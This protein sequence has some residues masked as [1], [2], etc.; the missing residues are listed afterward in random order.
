M[1]NRYLPTALR[2]A[3]DKAA[4]DARIVAEEG[5]RDAIRRLGVADS[6]APAYLKDEKKELRRRLRAHA[7]ALG[8]AFDKTEDTQGTKRLVEAAAY[9]HW[10]RMLFARFLAERGLLRNPEHDVPVTLEDCR[11]L[12]EAEG[13]TDAWAIAERYA[14][15]MLPAVFRIDDPVLALDLDPV[16]TQKLHRLVTDLDAE[17]FQ[18]EDS[19]GWTYQFWRAAEKKAVNKSGVKIGA[20]ELPAVTQLF[21]EPYMVRFL[22]HNTLGAW[23]AGKKLAADP[24]LAQT[25]ADEDA[26]RAAC[27]PADY[28]FDML[29]FVREG[30][31]DPWR[32]AAGTFPGWPK[33]AKAITVLDPCCGSGHFLTEALA[34]LAALRQA[35]EHLSS[36]DSV[37]A[38]LRDNL[39]GL[40]I[41]GRCVQIAAFAVALTAW[42]IGGWQTLPLPQI[43]WVGA[44][45]PLP[46]REFIALADGK[47]ELEY[48]LAALHDLFAQAPVLGS[49]LEPSGGDLFESEKLKE[50]ERLLEPLL[51]KARKAEPEHSEGVIAARGMA[52][53]AEM[54]SKNFIL[55]ATN[56][57]FLHRRRQNSHLQDYLSKH[58]PASKE[59]LSS[60]MC[61][62]MLRSSKD[63]GTTALVLPQNCYFLKTYSEFRR[64]LVERSTFS[65]IARL[66][67]KAFSTPM[68]DYNMSLSIFSN[69]PPDKNYS[70]PTIDAAEHTEISEKIDDLLRAKAYGFRPQNALSTPNFMIEFEES[71]QKKRLSDYASSYQGSGLGDIRR[72]RQMFWEVKDFREK[73]VLHA[74]S[75]SAGKSYSGCSFATLWESGRGDLASHP[76]V[77]LRGRSAWNKS[78]VAVAWLGTLPAS[79]YHGWLYD[80]SASVIIPHKAS[81]LT[82]LWAYISSEEYN[83]DVRKINQKPQVANATLVEVPFD[84][85][86]WRKIAGERCL[87]GIPEPLSNDA[88]QWLFHGHPKAADLGTGLQVALARLCGYRWPAEVD[89]DMRLSDEAREWIAKAAKLP[90]GDN[91]GL[92]GVPPVAGEKS[93]ADRLRGYLAAAFGTDWSDALERRLIAEADEVLDKKAARAR[94]GS[95]EAW[96]RDRAFRQHCA[97]FGQRPFL[98]HISDGLKDGFSVFA[99]YHRFDKANLRKLTYTLLGDWLARAKAENNALRYEKGR[100]L[101]QWLGKVLEGEKPYDIFVR[102]KSLAQQ[103][104]GWDPDLDDGVRQNIRPFIKAG[105]LTHDLSKILKDKDRGKD[106]ASA[107]WYP[108]FNGE[109]RNDHHT[110]L[111]EKRAA[112]EA[113]ARRVEAAK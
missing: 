42:R 39:H 21:T 107:P 9:A 81:D 67:V 10:H 29:R 110:T 95:L 18:A 94:D 84:I 59:D 80:N 105:L 24:A 61:E 74:S 90:P 41:D 70:C 75:P 55:Q 14:A 26:L 28:N 73:W 49:L 53:A 8:D 38:V 100:E 63:G 17:V 50:I 111:A 31:D 86:K 7:R 85:E 64:Q 99:D 113:A 13:L 47:P 30:E 97:L 5:S 36:A 20:D 15:S 11:E 96:V 16:H 92:L 68:Y 51:R 103:P 106:V 12:A 25:A 54:V 35:E 37:A 98:W 72:F 19:L 78:G 33:K 82:V 34:I 6:K 108:V 69:S 71:C 79:L 112:R 45:P 91:D 104:L 93:L 1:S 77:T 46:R 65:M 48:A 58:L 22:L 23:W 76:D 60:A 109:R 2:R 62:R 101:Q 87:D 56:V 66:G 57:P 102:W 83:I 4:K 89:P 32:P 3:L 52:D 40:E 44:R 88:S 27:S 43:A